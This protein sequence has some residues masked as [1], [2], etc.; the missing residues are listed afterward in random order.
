MP[1]PGVNRLSKEDNSGT[2]HHGTNEQEELICVKLLRFYLS[3]F[4]S[5]E[6][7]GRRYQGQQY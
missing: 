3:P 1:A 6:I 2:R 7:E 4:K 5:P